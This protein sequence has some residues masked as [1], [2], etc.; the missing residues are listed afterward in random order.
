MSDK[1]QGTDISHW[2]GSNLNQQEAADSGMKFCIPKATEGRDFEDPK[3]EENF[4][5]ISEVTGQTYY[6]GAYH[7]ARP[8]TDEGLQRDCVLLRD[9]DTPAFVVVAGKITHGQLQRFPGI[10]A[11]LDIH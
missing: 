1:I 9:G 4:N 10:S 3:F 7:Y 6:P 2:Q 5:E 8:D 11:F